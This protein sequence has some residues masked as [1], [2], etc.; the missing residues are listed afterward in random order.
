MIVQKIEA[1]GIKEVLLD[2]IVQIKE[3]I[4]KDLYIKFAGEFC[5]ITPEAINSAIKSI[6]ESRMYEVKSFSTNDSE[7]ERLVEEIASFFSYSK[8]HNIDLNNDIVD[9]I[10]KL[11][12]L[13]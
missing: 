7:K 8:K 5:G 12:N 11:G 1:R 9:R 10:S 4:T 2:I 6:K 3:P 13:F